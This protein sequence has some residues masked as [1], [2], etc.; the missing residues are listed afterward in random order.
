MNKMKL[1][2]F[3][4]SN[5]SEMWFSRV[6]DLES[7]IR[8]CYEVNKN[9]E[10][11][12]E[13]EL[14]YEDEILNMREDMDRL[15]IL[16]YPTEPR[17][18]TSGRFIKPDE[19][20][21]VLYKFILEPRTPTPGTRYSGIK[22]RAGFEEFPEINKEQYNRLSLFVEEVMTSIEEYAIKYF[23]MNERKKR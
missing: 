4:R 5:Y 15:E 19:K 11:N 21:S 2:Y 6:M 7:A 14:K 13:V 16:F 10:E 23:Y 18:E 17:I 22:V 9:L 1:S 8:F 3:E 20:L 12:T